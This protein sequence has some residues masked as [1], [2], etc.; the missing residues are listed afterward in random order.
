MPAVVLRWLGVGILLTSVDSVVAG[1]LDGIGRASVN[2]KFSILEVLLYAPLLAFLVHRTGIE[3][4][5]IAWSIRC[6]VDICVRMSIAQRVYAP[7]RPAVK[8]VLP[9]LL[10]VTVVLFAAAMAPGQTILLVIALAGSGGVAI[11][12]WWSLS[13]G[14]RTRLLATAGRLLPSTSR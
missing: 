7:I 12:T 4:A 14:E 10:G 6:L 1:L 3:G 13:D 5:A 11:L 2:A 9:L 8:S